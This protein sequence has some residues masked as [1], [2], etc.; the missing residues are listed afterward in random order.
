MYDFFLV[1]HE[2]SAVVR[3]VSY[4]C[5][6]MDPNR[7]LCIKLNISKIMAKPLKGT[8]EKNSGNSDKR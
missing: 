7:N 1:K 8:F 6:I 5:V 4:F 3:K 2:K